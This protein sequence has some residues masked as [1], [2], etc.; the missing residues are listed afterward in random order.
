LS[1]LRPYTLEGSNPDDKEAVRCA[2]KEKYPF[3]QAAYL[4]E[5][6]IVTDPLEITKIV[7][8]MINKEISKG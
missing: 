4:T 5:D 3:S 2:V 1:L 6:N 7:E 8:E